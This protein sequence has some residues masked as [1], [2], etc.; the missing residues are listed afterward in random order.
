[1]KLYWIKGDFELL[2]VN[3]VEEG[4]TNLLDH[5]VHDGAMID[6]TKPIVLET[7]DW[8]APGDWIASDCPRAPAYGTLLLSER[9]V[10]VLGSMLTDAGYFLDT[11]LPGTDVRYKVFICDCELDAL[12]LERSELTRFRSGNIDRVLRHELKA[13]SLRGADVFRLKHRRS[14]VFVSDRF[15]AAVEQ[16]GLV[17]FVFEEIWS[18]ETGGVYRPREMPPIDRVPGESARRAKAKRRA[19]REVLA[20][21]G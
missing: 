7:S 14:D 20:R 15:K 11:V 2:W 3:C 1:M 21:Q 10:A 4:V 5:V 8:D 6:R 12:D 16:A 9:A 19:L 18:S 13:D 17:G